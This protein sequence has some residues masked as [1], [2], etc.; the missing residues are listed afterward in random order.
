[1]ALCYAVDYGY[2]KNWAPPHKNTVNWIGKLTGIKSSTCG[3]IA[4]SKLLSLLCKRAKHPDWHRNISL[5]HN[6]STI[7][8][9]QWNNGCITS[10]HQYNASVWHMHVIP[11]LI[12]CIWALLSSKVSKCV[13]PYLECCCHPQVCLC[14]KRKELLTSS[15]VKDMSRL[16]SYHARVMCSQCVC[17]RR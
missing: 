15:Y 4:K 6:K 14:E 12:H 1:M 5:N 7:H 10:A 3:K 17:G 16:S 8:Y 11:W 13:T 9:C 2:C